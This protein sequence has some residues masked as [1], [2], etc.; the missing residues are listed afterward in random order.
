MCSP[1]RGRPGQGGATL[2]ELVTALAAGMLVVLAALATLALLQTSAT[3]QG[4]ASRLQQR[5]EVALHAIGWQ[6]RQAGA[7][8]LRR[9]PDGTVSFSTA[10]DGYAGTGHAVSGDDG[11]QGRPDTL[12]VS[13]ED[14]ATSRDCLGNRPNGNLA[15]VRV[16]SRFAV[17]SGELRCLGA[18]A[19]TGAQVLIDGVEDFQ[20]RYGLRDGGAAGA[21]RRYVDA[22]GIAGRWSEVRAVSVCLQVRGEGRLDAGSGTA[23][24]A[25][26]NGNSLPA[27]GR[28]RRVARATF[29][30][31]NAAP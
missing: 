9:L 15:G 10:F 8:E 3:L 5:I 29:H 14:N 21:L 28:L 4:D 31:R 19:Q 23:S 13:H 25:G 2:I 11:A 20:V 12:R 16:D 6:L 17:V 1:E 22:A 24:P 30:L 18:N 26:C 7:V 27:D